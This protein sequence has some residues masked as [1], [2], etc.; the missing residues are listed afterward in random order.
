VGRPAIV[1]VPVGRRE[2]IVAALLL[3]GLLI[4]GSV[5]AVIATRTLESSLTGEAQLAQ[6]DLEHG[7][8]QLE[9]GYQR[10]DVAQVRAAATSFARS[11]SRL[12]ALGQRVR[13][14]DA[15]RGSAV[16]APVRDRVRSLEAVIDMG[17]HLD[18]AGIA[19][20]RAL[21]VSGMVGGAPPSVPDLTG[22]LAAVRDELGQAERAASAIDL[23]VLP[24]SQRASLGKALLELRTAV[25]G[26]NALWPSLSAVFDLL[27]LNGPRT[28]LIEQVNP[29][30]LRAGGGFIGTVSLVHA[31]RGH[32]TLA[33][34]LPVEAFDY[35]DADGCVHPRPRPWQPGYVAPPAEL[36]G[37]PLPIYSQLTAWSLE[38]SGFAPDFATNAATAEVF[39][40]RLLGVPIDGVIAVDYYA[41]AP[42]LELTGPIALPKY[43]LTLTADNFVDTVVGLDLARDYAHKDVIS[44]AAAKIVSGLSHISPANVPKLLRTVQDMVR[45]RHL[46]VHFDA[47]GVQHEALRLAATDTLNPLQATDFLL[48]TEDNYGGSKSNYFLRRTY[49][50]DLSRSGPLLHHQLTI[51]LHDGAP[52]DKQYIGPHYFAYVRITV[53][54]NATNVRVSSAPSKEYDRIEAPGRRTQVAPPGAQ[55]AGGWIFVL[56]GPG[57]SGDYQVMFTWDTRWTAGPDD[58]AT[59]YWQKQPGTVHDPVQVRWASPDGPRRASTELSEDRIVTLRPDG[60]TVRPAPAPAV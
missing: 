40:R 29:A 45:G 4:A 43:N 44:A 48:E 47:P 23:G 11:E 2:A 33:K 56:V 6:A 22:Q 14:L 42:L 41:V 55:V 13:P 60:L 16:P 37:P 30:E 15:A 38:D 59:F 57:L 49:Q 21:L 27:G 28:Y 19:A 32:V 24:G 35:C 46:Q 34:S 51:D 18:R 20:T 1:G 17:Q 5:G 8:K 25:D 36:A 9:D 39:A 58:T 7:L 52:A 10:E 50:L 3:V 26:L 54:A 12:R 53:P 31:E